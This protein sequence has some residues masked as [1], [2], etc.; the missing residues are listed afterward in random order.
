MFGG[1][2]ELFMISVQNHL[3]QLNGSNILQVNDEYGDWLYRQ[4]LF[5]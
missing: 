3:Q 4:S 2:T 1:L 5:L